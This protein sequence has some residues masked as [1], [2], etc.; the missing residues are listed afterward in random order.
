MLGTGLD[1]TLMA[2]RVS[3]KHFLK[4]CFDYAEDG[5]ALL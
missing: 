3:S 5:V 1:A 4:L 2:K